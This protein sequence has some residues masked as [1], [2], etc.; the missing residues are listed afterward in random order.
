MR[1]LDLNDPLVKGVI[2][3]FSDIDLEDPGDIE[4]IS[5]IVNLEK[6]RLKINNKYKNSNVK[7]LDGP[8]SL[9]YAKLSRVAM[10]EIDKINKNRKSD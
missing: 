2:D 3:I 6:E 9:E 8:G 1:G 7:G 4:I 5:I 10:N